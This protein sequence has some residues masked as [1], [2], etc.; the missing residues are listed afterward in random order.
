MKISDDVGLIPA[1]CPGQLPPWEV[2]EEQ[3]S[4]AVTDK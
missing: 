3:G 4:T 2:G 1:A